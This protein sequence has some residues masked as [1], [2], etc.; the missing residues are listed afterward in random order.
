[1]LNKIVSFFIRGGLSILIGLLIG[2]SI[3]TIDYQTRSDLELTGSTPFLIA[4]FIWF[5]GGCY[6]ISKIKKPYHFSW[7]TK[8]EKE[9]FESRE[10]KKKK[11]LEDNMFRVKQL[12]DSQIITQEEYEE[13][14]KSLKEKYF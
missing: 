8:V 14:I 6:T 3:T 13:R 9:F 11:K 1:M 2:A 12:F 7:V 10:D 4:C 5:V